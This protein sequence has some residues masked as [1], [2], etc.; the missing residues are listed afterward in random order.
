MEQYFLCE[1]KRRTGISTFCFNYISTI[2]LYFLHLFP[3]VLAY[4][5]LCLVFFAARSERSACLLVLV[6]KMQWKASFY[7]LEINVKY[8]FSH[9]PESQHG[10]F[11]LKLATRSSDFWCMLRIDCAINIKASTENQRRTYDI[12]FFKVSLKIKSVR[13]TIVYNTF[14]VILFK[15][16]F[17]IS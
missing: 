9:F 7:Q 14:F 13:D 8:F 12:D 4:S 17:G 2:T 15:K 11:F 5:L 3:C 10:A 1:T 16:L 6:H